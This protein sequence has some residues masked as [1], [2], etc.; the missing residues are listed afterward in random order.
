VGVERVLAIENSIEIY[1]IT[2]DWIRFADAK[3]AVVLTV[4]GALAGLLIPCLKPY[5]ESV[6]GQTSVAWLAP[7]VIGCYGMW[8][9]LLVLSAIWS[10]LCIIPYRKG[11]K[12][13]SLG[14]CRHFHGAAI[15]TAYRV[16]EVDRF[17]ETYRRL[18]HENL[19]R[20]VMA[21]LL[22][23]AHISSTKYAH[24][25]RSIRVLAWSSVFGFLFLLLSQF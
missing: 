16:E 14:A 13:P 24:V 7:V 23:D 19:L 18:G 3:A 10:F 5:L 9:L 22:I 2:A 25:A 4:N 21:G 8:L 17:F 11:G 1:K 20:E 12:H 15:G 6:K